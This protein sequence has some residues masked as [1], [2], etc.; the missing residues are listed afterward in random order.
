MLHKHIIVIKNIKYDLNLNIIKIKLS[1][2]YDWLFSPR[3]MFQY[4]AQTVIIN[5]N[6]NSEINLYNINVQSY[7]SLNT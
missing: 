4:G 6:Y 7:N 3:L 2:F 1:W 5:N